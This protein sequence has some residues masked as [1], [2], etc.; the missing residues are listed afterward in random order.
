MEDVAKRR[1]K[2]RNAGEADTGMKTCSS[3][4]QVASQLGQKDCARKDHSLSGDSRR[5]LNTRPK[6]S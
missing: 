3:Q 4:P 1:G 6:I 2:S 5:A